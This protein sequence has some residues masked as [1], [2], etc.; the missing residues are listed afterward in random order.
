MKEQIRANDHSLED[1]AKIVC[2]AN[3]ERWH[4]KMAEQKAGMEYEQKLKN[5]LCSHEAQCQAKPS[6]SP[7]NNN[8]QGNK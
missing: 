2:C 3:H 6:S 5:L 4:N 1:L 7:G 8:K